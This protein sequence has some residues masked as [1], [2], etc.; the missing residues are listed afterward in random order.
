[1]AHYI[2][3]QAVIRGDNP[4][5]KTVVLYGSTDVSGSPFGLSNIVPTWR[6]CFQESTKVAYRGALP[7]TPPKLK[8]QPRELDDLE[9]LV[10]ALKPELET[11]LGTPSEGF[12]EAAVMGAE[13]LIA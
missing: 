3:S 8:P 2:S 13:T 12:E 6:Y 7:S 10:D 1:M 11:M 5:T 4:P 9:V